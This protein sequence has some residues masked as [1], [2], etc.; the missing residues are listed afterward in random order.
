MHTHQKHTGMKHDTNAER[1]GWGRRACNEA[2]PEWVEGRG[3]RARRVEKLGRGKKLA[4]RARGFGERARP[5]E[6][7]GGKAHARQGKINPLG[8]VAESG[9]R[10]S[11]GRGEGGR[12]ESG[13]AG[14]RATR[15]AHSRP[16][17]PHDVRK[18]RTQRRPLATYGNVPRPVHTNTY[19]VRATN[20]ASSLDG[21]PYCRPRIRKK[22]TAG[23]TTPPANIQCDSAR[24]NIAPGLQPVAVKMMSTTRSKPPA[25]TQALRSALHAS[26]TRR[27]RRFSSALAAVSATVAARLPASN[28]SSERLAMALSTCWVLCEGPCTRGQRF[29]QSHLERSNACIT[30]RQEPV[31]APTSNHQRHHRTRHA[32]TY[33]R[34]RGYY[35]RGRRAT[36]AARA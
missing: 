11:G 9:G 7:D 23:S 15:D 4:S 14:G 35:A 21:Q 13:V 25:R 36:L 30:R 32:A 2:S 1:V 12:E 19:E 34:T 20:A 3:D 8:A 24:L 17:T 18:R 5:S 31:Y 33:L 28:S 16:A 22:A 27:L 10:E 6:A 26:A 29:G